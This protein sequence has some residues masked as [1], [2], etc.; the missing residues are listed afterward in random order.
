M[1]RNCFGKACC[2]GPGARI[3]RFS[4]DLGSWG[5]GELVGAGVVAREEFGGFRV[6]G[7]GIQEL[8]LYERIRV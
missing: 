4:G 5:F 7:C 8:E 3:L 2:K 6:R 1:L